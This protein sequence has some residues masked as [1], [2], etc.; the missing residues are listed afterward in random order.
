MTSAPFLPLFTSVSWATIAGVGASGLALEP[1]EPPAMVA[2]RSAY[3]EAPATPLVVTLTDRPG[4]PHEAPAPAEDDDAFA[5]ALSLDAP[6]AAPQVAALASCAGVAF[7]V[8]VAAPA[9]VAD[10]K[11]DAGALAAPA[12]AG[13][14][15]A[16][17]RGVAVTTITLGNGRFGAGLA[18]P[19][20]PESA[21]INGHEGA[22][23]VRFAVARSGR[24]MVAKVV[25]GAG[26]AALDIEALD[27]VRRRWVF[28]AGTPPGPFE[29]T[30][31]FVLQ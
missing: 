31:H 11:G 13:G 6:Q 27:T 26:H 9:G 2:V 5:S 28:P 4:A 7:A 12:G 1:P 21:R 14:E 16:G 19:S 3:A 24:V 23:T 22:V 30:A 17:A 20:Y 8:P 10:S 25:R 29:W 15:H 18:R